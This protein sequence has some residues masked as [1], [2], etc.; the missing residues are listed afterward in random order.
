MSLALIITNVSALA[1]TS[2][3]VWRA[4]INNLLIDYGTVKGHVRSDGWAALVQKLLDQ[5]SPSGKDVE[6][7]STGGKDTQVRAETINTTDRQHETQPS[8]HPNRRSRFD[9]D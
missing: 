2:D 3:Y 9:P 5:R 7:D 4:Q 1:P 6:R 8:K